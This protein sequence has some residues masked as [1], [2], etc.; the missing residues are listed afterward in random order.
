MLKASRTTRS[1]ATYALFEDPI[2]YATTL[3]LESY[4][5]NA[6]RLYDAVERHA[7]E[8]EG[9]WSPTSPLTP[10]SEDDVAPPLTS[11]NSRSSVSPQDVLD[12]LNDLLDNLDVVEKLQG[13]HTP[14]TSRGDPAPHAPAPLNCDYS[15]DS[16][17]YSDPSMVGSRKRARGNR[18]RRKEK[19]KQRK[20]LERA[21]LEREREAERRKG[22]SRPAPSTVLP[23]PPGTGKSSDG[24]KAYKKRK[25]ADKRRAE[26]QDAA[27]A[28]P[29][30]RKHSRPF[31]Q[32][33]HATVKEI[34]LTT[35]RV[36]YT[37]RRGGYVAP[38]HNMHKVTTVEEL[39]E[40]GIEELHWNGTDTLVLLDAKDRIFAVLLGAP[41]GLSNDERKS[42]EA[43]MAELATTLERLRAENQA[44]FD[45]HHSRGDF[46]AFAAGFTGSNG[47]SSPSNLKFE[48]N[49]HRAVAEELLQDGNMRRLAGFASAALAYYF[50]LIYMH[51]CERLRA[52]CE[53]DPSLRFPFGGIS[54]YPTITFNMGPVSITFGHNDGTN[55]AGIPCSI[56]SLGSF[57]AGEGGHLI[58]YDVGV[59]FQF[60]AG[61]T[62]LLSS[63]GLR[64]GNT[65]LASAEERRYSVTQY[66]QGS[67][68]RWVARG[69]RPS[70]SLSDAEKDAVDLEAGEGWA[71]QYLRFSTWTS[72][73]EDRER[74]R[75]WEQSK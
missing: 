8:Q 12:A 36:R 32:H 30:D 35:F 53:H 7:E 66:C 2:P 75:L 4:I 56:T 10:L 22:D 51:M 46:A 62:V 1:G 20:E 29:Y 21:R 55:Y 37:T 54:A 39:R 74:L 31:F 67:L 23:K 3:P 61:C 64:H 27:N 6:V 45:M 49:G 43:A 52:L 63:A 57:N 73:A 41:K 34:N 68:I 38:S 26:R 28:Q 42:W 44:S 15:S 25:R 33:K 17:G 13:P 40:M 69:F 24:K 19:E 9:A 47:K 16:S 50:P 58:L 60:P 14:S 59:Y 48:N 70:G 72:V 18:Q 11:S 65:P 71:S 5:K